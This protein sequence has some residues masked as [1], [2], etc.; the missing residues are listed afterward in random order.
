MANPRSIE[1]SKTM[2]LRLPW[3]LYLSINSDVEQ[4][5]APSVNERILQLIKQGQKAEE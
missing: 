3:Q 1:P 2:T 4:G 5:K